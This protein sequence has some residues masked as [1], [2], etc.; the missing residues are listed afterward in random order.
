MT[1][2]HDPR[3]GAEEP[4]RRRSVNTALLAHTLVEISPPP[5]GAAQNLRGENP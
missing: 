5:A 1:S 2:S 4:D 3:T